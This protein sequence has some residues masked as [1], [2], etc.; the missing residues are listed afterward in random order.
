CPTC[1]STATLSPAQQDRKAVVTSPVPDPNYLV[2]TRSQGDTSGGSS[3][4]INLPWEGLTLAGYQ[5]VRE[6]GRGGMGV[7]Y[8][9]YDQK[10]GVH[11]AVKTL[12]AMEPRAFYRFKQEFRALA[13]VS[14]PNL[15][16]LHELIS[17]GERWFF[18]MELVDGVSFLDY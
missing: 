6:L 11:V 2:P 17:V 1:G 18:T 3:P 9:G 15:A 8:K 10:R 13:D 4:A 12:P 14:H 5:I 7:V 16:A